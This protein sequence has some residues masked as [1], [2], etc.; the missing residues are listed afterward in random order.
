MRTYKPAVAMGA[1]KVGHIITLPEN[2]RI[3]IWKN[4]DGLHLQGHPGELAFAF[5][6]VQVA[7]DA[8]ENHHDA[9]V[10]SWCSMTELHIDHAGVLTFA[11]VPPE[12]GPIE[13]FRLDGKVRRRLAAALRNL[14]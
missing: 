1:S 14:S 3:E 6:G 13:T 11:Q 5:D 12:T 8:L 2:R 4:H 10:R 7:V 9:I